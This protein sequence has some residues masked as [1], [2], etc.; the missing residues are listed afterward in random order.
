M[1]FFKALS[2]R[3]S[4]ISKDSRCK[5]IF[6]YVEGRV[7][8]PGLY[9]FESPVSVMKFFKTAGLKEDSNL[10]FLPYKKLIKKS[11]SLYV[12]EK[13]LACAKEKIMP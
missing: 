4:E 9:I 12:P 3:S 8:K 1:I 5:K 10:K 13:E 6:I 2:F 11:C 7:E